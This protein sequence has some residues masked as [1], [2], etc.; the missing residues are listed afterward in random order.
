VW[1]IDWYLM[2]DPQA[3]T[4]ANNGGDILRAAHS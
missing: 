1:G 3:Y 4:V 2:L